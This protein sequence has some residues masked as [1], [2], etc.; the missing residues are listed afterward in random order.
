MLT[1]DGTDG[2]GQILRTSLSLGAIHGKSF[3][4]TSIRAKRSKPGLQAQHLACV[5]AVQTITGAHVDGA[6]LGAIELRYNHQV[7]PTSSPCNNSD[8]VLYPPLKDFVF[9][10]GTAGSAMLLLQTI[11]PILLFSC[12]EVSTFAIEGGTHNDLAPSSSFI[13]ETFLP[14]VRKLGVRA[15]I[16]TERVGLMPEGNG[17]VR[18]VVEPIL[19]LHALGKLSLIGPKTNGRVTAKVFFKNSSHPSFQ[20]L[21][22]ITGSE[23]LNIISDIEEISC[24]RAKKPSYALCLFV[25]TNHDLQ[26]VITASDFKNNVHNILDKAKRELGD[27]LISA[28]VVNEYLSDQLL[29]YL[30]LGCDIEYNIDTASEHFTTNMV[31]IQQFYG[32]QKVIDVNSENIVRRVS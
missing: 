8:S 18:V 24:G 17:K 3:V 19:D 13:Q 2:G 15:E 14:I 11:L 30:A 28:C 1:I 25:E 21:L 27:Y 16:V 23:G 22:Q 31:V 29:L 7:P 9:R 6:E 32:D 12:R 20:D 5:Q 26:M 10:I 4:I